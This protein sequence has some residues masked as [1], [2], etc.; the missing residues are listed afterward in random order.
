MTFL[1][2]AEVMAEGD[3]SVGW[4]LT[5]NSVGQLIA[6]SL[7]DAGVDEIFGSGADTIVAGTAVPGGGTAVPVAGG[8]RS[9][10]LAVRQR[11]PREPVE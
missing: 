2:V 10:A 8:Y 3:A 6:L 5:N 7:P 11:L 4:N 9:P 1:R